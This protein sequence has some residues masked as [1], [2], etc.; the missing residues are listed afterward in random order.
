LAFSY[1]IDKTLVSYG[2]KNLLQYLSYL[3]LRVSQLAGHSLHHHRAIYSNQDFFWRRCRGKRRL[4][5]G[6]FRTH[7]LYFV[8]CFALL[9]FYL[10][11]FIKNTK[12]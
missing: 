7:I 12:K 4:L 8:Y 9:Y 11:H 1:W 3:P 10:H 6:E 5:Q 2:G